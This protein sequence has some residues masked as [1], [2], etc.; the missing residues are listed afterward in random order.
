MPIINALS[1][2][3]LERYSSVSGCVVRSTEDPG[4]TSI[5]IVPYRAGRGMVNVHVSST[6]LRWIA[7]DGLWEQV[8]VPWQ[9]MEPLLDQARGAGFFILDDKTADAMLSA[10]FGTTTQ[11]NPL[12]LVRFH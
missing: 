1:A 9:L 12:A 10:D 4:S 8:D 3:P 2:G 11:A 6:H 5:L 7:A